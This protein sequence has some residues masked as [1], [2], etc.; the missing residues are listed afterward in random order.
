MRQTLFNIGFAG[1]FALLAVI[2]PAMV[3]SVQAEDGPKAADKVAVVNGVN[4]ERVEFE[5]EMLTFER[6]ILQ[7]GKP[8]T[9][10]QLETVEKEVLES[11]VRRELLYQD[12]HNAGVKPDEKAVDKELNALKDQFPDE[13]AYKNELSKRNMTVELLRAQL[14]RNSAVQQYIERQFAA[15]AAVTDNDMVAYYEGHMNLFSQPEQ[16]RVSHIFIQRD[17]KSDEPHKQEARRKADQIMN[18]LK[19][20]KDFAALAKEYSDDQRANGGDLG[21]LKMGQLEKRFES[22]VF[23][24]NSG[25]TTGIIEADNGFHIF[26]VTDKKAATVLAYEDVKEKIRAFLRE[27]KAKQEADLYARKL[28]EKAKVERFPIE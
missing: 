17:P 5:G 25:E 21:Y 2:L 20:G 8:L 26:K 15:K 11:M 1:L 9:C 4:I 18:D 14:V 19:K 10:K 3:L 13:T 24:L 12:A 22:P 16:I 28:V 27:E 7:F 23:A 6:N